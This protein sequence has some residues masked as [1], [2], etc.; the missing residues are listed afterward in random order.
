MDRY[1]KLLKKHGADD[2]EI[3][4]VKKTGWE[5]YFIG[6]R[7]DQHR[8][9]DVEYI[10]LKAYKRSKDGQWMGC[11][12]AKLSP[13]ETG[14]MLDKIVENLVY[15]ASLVKNK[16]Y[17]LNTPV[18]AQTE[19]A[20][21]KTNAGEAQAFIR[22]MDSIPETPTEFLNSYEI[23][24]GQVSTRLLTS[25]GIDVSQTGTRS[26]LDVVVNAR[27]GTHEIE[28]YRL[29]EM[30]SCDPEKLTVDISELLTFGRDRLKAVPTPD[31]LHVPVIFSTDA[32]LMIYRFFLSQINAAYVVR[33]MSGFALGESFAKE[34]T[35]DRLTLEALRML[36]GSPK[37]GAYDPEGALIRDT[38]LIRDSVPCA[39]VGE[40]MFSQY[41][42]LEDSF[43]V[44]NWKV[45]GGTKSEEEIRSGQ[46]LEVVEFSDFQ[47]DPVTGDV[48]GEIR[49]AYYND[50]N[51][52][53][54]PVTGGSISGNI[55]ENLT[56]MHM[57]VR[58]R[59]FSHALIPALTKLSHLTIAG[60]EDESR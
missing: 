56:D 48:F 10:T 25:E 60:A 58:S 29:F 43:I 52:H 55:K 9:K 21:L 47:V 8:A 53:T 57:S 36:P 15:R 18:D 13:D 45:S 44:S 14:E 32:A 28:L 38:V 20:P 39:F 46:Y 40:R 17:R 23:F 31:H 33:G 27:E 24:T 12:E 34:I 37:N 19:D 42:G 41:L 2:W 26:M 51:D 1:I 59:Q 49:L 16:P 54:I 7:L 35:G 3:L 50:G 4:S 11:A 5:F 30:G 22:T 6:H